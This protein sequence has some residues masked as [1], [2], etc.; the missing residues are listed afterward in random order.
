[1]DQ[2]YFSIW[3]VAANIQKEDFNLNSGKWTAYVNKSRKTGKLLEQ[4]GNWRVG[5]Q[6]TSHG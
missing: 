3:F 6:F 5:R 4:Y 1:M 2:F